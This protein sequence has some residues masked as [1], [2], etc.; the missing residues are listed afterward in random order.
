MYAT[1]S[2]PFFLRDSRVSETRAPVKKW[3]TTRSLAYPEYQRFFSRRREFSLLAEGRHI[4]TRQ[5]P[6]TALEKSLAP[7]VMY[8]K[9]RKKNASWPLRF[10]TNSHN[11]ALKQVNHLSCSSF[12]RARIPFPLPWRDLE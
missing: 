2:P 9:T 10:K 7:R 1:S 12:L 6:E 3:G 8:A 11:F 4:K 5:K